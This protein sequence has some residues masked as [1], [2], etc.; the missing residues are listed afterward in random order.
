MDASRIEGCETLHVF[1]RID[2]TK[3]HFRVEPFD[4]F[5]SAFFLLCSLHDSLLS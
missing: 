5:L 2:Q 1:Y 4:A 3:K